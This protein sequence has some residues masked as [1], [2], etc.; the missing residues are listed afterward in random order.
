MSFHSIY[1]CPL[2]SSSVESYCK[3]DFRLYLRC[4][5]CSLIFVPPQYHVSPDEEK[6]RYA[7]HRNTKDNENYVA[8]LSGIAN[9]ILDLTEQPPSVLDFGCGE[10]QVLSDILNERGARCASYDPLYGISTI[11][12]GERYDIV[13]ACE[14]F[15]HLRGVKKELDL[16]AGLMKPDGFL[17]VRTLLYDG[18]QDFASWWYAKDVTHVN[19]FC[20]MSMEK[21]GEIMGI[22]LL[23]SDKRNTVVFSNG[24]KAKKKWTWKPNFEGEDS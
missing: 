1:F 14:V 24:A 2:C 12:P 4:P 13:V 20:E 3:D 17:F 9:E 10:Y 8:Y 19:F 7:R 23:S 15:E 11:T 6:L 16:V 22:K 5:S 18:V 21:V